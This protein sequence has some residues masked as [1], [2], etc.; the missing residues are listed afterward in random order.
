VHTEFWWLSL[1]ERD[2]LECL[3]VDK[4]ITLKQM[5]HTHMM[6]AWTGLILLRIG[7]DGLL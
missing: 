4:R 7:M 1:R 6:R 3:D 5:F 2:H